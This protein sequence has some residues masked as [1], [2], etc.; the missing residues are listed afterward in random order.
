MTVVEHELDCAGFAH[1]EQGIRP[2]TPPETGDGV[3]YLPNSE[4]LQWASK[5]TLRDED[6][7]ETWDDGQMEG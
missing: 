7:S 2:W 6:K 4:S 5:W 3:A 1:D